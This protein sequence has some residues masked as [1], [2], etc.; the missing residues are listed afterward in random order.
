MQYFLLRFLVVIDCAIVE[1]IDM[2]VA[3]ESKYAQ[4]NSRRPVFD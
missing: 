3:G 2:L 4:Q 1:Y